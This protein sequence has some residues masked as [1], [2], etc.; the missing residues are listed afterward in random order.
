MNQDQAMF[1]KRKY[2]L[3]N[4]FYVQNLFWSFCPQFQ[5][6]EA[7]I[8]Q[9]FSQLCHFFTFLSPL[10]HLEITIVA[11]EKKIFKKNKDIHNASLACNIDGMP[12]FFILF[13]ENWVLTSSLFGTSLNYA[14]KLSYI[15]LYENTKLFMQL[16]M[17]L[18]SRFLC[19]N[20]PYFLWT[21]YVLWIL[22]KNSQN[23]FF[24]S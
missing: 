3:F 8:C 20:I 21:V 9:I 10:Y 23:A 14:G 6:Y 18:I 22:I 5:E 11:C 7:K 2:P 4:I 24:S 13:C 15:L 19:P 1:L 12:K 16:I 17:I